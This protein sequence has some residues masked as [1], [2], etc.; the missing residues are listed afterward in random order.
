MIEN[1]GTGPPRLFETAKLAK[2]QSLQTFAWSFHEHKKA[3]LQSQHRHVSEF[4]GQSET[5]GPCRRFLRGALGSRPF[6]KRNFACVP[7]KHRFSCLVHLF[8]QTHVLELM[9]HLVSAIQLD[10]KLPG[11]FHR[12]RKNKTTFVYFPHSTSKT[13]RFVFCRR[14]THREPASWGRATLE[15]AYHRKNRPKKITS[16]F[17]PTF[18]E[19]GVSY[20]KSV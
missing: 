1:E 18:L 10:R 9:P 15:S 17:S 2:G 13:M 16:I 14:C 19:S 4:A 8:W 11:I 6:P 20:Q 7:S 12:L 3:V 5:S